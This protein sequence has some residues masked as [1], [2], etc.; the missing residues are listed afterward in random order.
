MDKIILHDGTE[1]E[2][3]IISRTGEKQIFISIPGTDIVNATLTFCDSD[4]TQ[5]MVCFTSVYKYTYTGYTHLGSITIDTFDERTHIYMTGDDVSY[6]IRNSVNK[7]YLPEEMIVPGE[8]EYPD[9]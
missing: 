2:G 9:A 6:Q 1:I 8:E 4:K 5:E 3:G 7:Q